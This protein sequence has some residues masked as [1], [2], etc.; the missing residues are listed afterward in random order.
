MLLIVNVADSAN[1]VNFSPVS[2]QMFH[3]VFGLALAAVSSSMI[4]YTIA[5]FIDVRMFHFWKKK[6]K[7]K[8]LWLRNNASTILSQCL[9]TFVVLLVL[10]YF[11]GIPWSSFGVLFLNGFLF[12]IFFAAF[13][14]PIIYM[15]CDYLRGKYDLKFG[16]SISDKN[17]T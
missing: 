2:N 11:G 13:D 17:K 7:G 14:T 9:D 5:Q 6:T 8:H 1:A 4:A 16:Q 15:C 3:T 12:K 10:A